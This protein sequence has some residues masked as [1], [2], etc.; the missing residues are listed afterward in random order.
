MKLLISA[1]LPM[2]L[3][4]CNSQARA[5]EK[6]QYLR[7]QCVKVVDGKT[8]DFAAILPEN[9]KLAKVRVD[10]GIATMSAVAVAQYPA[11]RSAACDY[12]FVETYDGFP[13]APATTEQADAA[14]TKSGITMSRA[15]YLTKLRGS[16]YLVSRDRP[17]ELRQWLDMFDKHFVGLTGSETDIRAVQQAT[18]VPVARKTD[19]HDGN[20][21]VAHANFVLAYTKDNLA[22][23]IYP[24]GVNR[25][26]WVH[27]LPLLIRETWRRP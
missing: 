18:G 26:D 8:A 14:F 1:Y 3:L 20:Y 13:P 5:Q 2:I 15:D 24:G 12:H 7:V 23:V 4:V 19:V 21:A 22:H 25:D 6:P 17:T 10:S 27:D 16:S 9:R 11:G